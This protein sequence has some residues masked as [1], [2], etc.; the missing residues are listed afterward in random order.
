MHAR[1]TRESKL[2]L[3]LDGFTDHTIN[4]GE[5]EIGYS[6][7]PDNGPTLLM[8]H[9]VTSRRDG[10]LRVIPSLVENHRV[11]TMD[12]RGHGYSGHTPGNYTRGDHAR[13]IRYVLDNVCKEQTIV[14]GHSMG[15]GNAIVMAGDEPEL[16]KALVLEDAAVFGKTRPAPASGSPVINTFKVHLELIETGLS[17]EEMAPKL[18]AASP[19]QPDYFAPWKAECL[20]QM[21]AEILRDVVSG[22]AR[23][24]G[25]DPVESLAKI[26]VPVLLLQADPTAGGILPD[27]YLAEILPE[28]EGFTTKKIVGAGHNINREHPDQLLPIV[29]PWLAKFQ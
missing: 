26:K 27:D 24:G 6:V 20:L 10:F 3:L 19:N 23:G 28:R 8:L 16:L 21:D 18:Q 1:P 4:T 15:G 22:K 29:L 5:V 25:D 14:W 12:Q 13:D 2:P 17:I 11:I 7:G 9:G